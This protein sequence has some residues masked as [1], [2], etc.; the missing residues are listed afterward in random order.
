RWEAA[1]RKIRDEPVQTLTIPL[2][3]AFVG[4]IT[5]K[6][7]VEMLFYPLR[8]RGLPLW[9]V[10]GQP[11]GLIGWQGIVPAKAASM[12]SRMVD[13]VT[14]Q[15]VDVDAVFARLNPHRVARL[16]SPEVT[17]MTQR[18]ATDL[19]PSGLDW[20]PAAAGAGLSGEGMDALKSLRHRMLVDL[21]RDMQRNLQ[22]AHL[23]ELVVGEM[24]A[25]RRVIVELFQR[26]GRAEF[27]FLVDSGFYF[28]FLLGIIQMFVWLLICDKAWTLPVGGAIVGYI[29]NWLALEIIFKPVEPIKFG[30][31]VFHGL[32]LQRQAEVAAEFAAFF[33]SKILTSRNIW[34]VI[35]FGSRAP[36]FNAML[37]KHVRPFL[38]QASALA[39][40]PLD[41]TAAAGLTAR[42]AAKLPDHVHVLHGYTDEAL[43]LGSTM[44]TQMRKM[45]SKNFE[46]VLHPI[47]QE[48]ELTLILAG[49]VL[50]ALAGGLQMLLSS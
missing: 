14:D 36:A 34:R 28:G 12:A 35:L 16:L 15:L 25:D 30:G 38:R 39:G 4:W 22:K 40:V 33:S 50:G 10:E 11:L 32:F 1:L 6:L 29:T 31:F 20:L 41:E 24:L 26:C 43:G 18:V 13:M 46:E 5:N 3:A 42:M 45:S 44:D 19:L 17:K 49:G 27:K 8:W 37:G 9:V 47:F 7:A 23:K 48:D 2:S 21:V